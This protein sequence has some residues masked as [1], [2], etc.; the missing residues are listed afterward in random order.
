MSNGSSNAGKDGRAGFGGTS[1]LSAT[2]RA[3][4]A[5]ASADALVGPMESQGADMQAQGTDDEDNLR[6]LAGRAPSYTGE[7]GRTC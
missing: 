2:N 3:D 7:E 5:T 4:T 6:E 1:R